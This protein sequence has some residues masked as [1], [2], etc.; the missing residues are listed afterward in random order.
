MIKCENC[1]HYDLCVE[2]MA[3]AKHQEKD[4]VKECLSEGNGC[5]DHFKD[6]ALFVE[7]PCKVGDKLFV[8]SQMRDKRILPFINEYLCTSISIKKR[9]ITVYHEMD[10]YIKIFKQTDF[11]KT[12]F[13]TKEEAERKLKEENK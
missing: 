1:I 13:L 2:L 8:L 7:L 4:F 10:G 3:H 6:E 9:S 12:V 5:T 11:G